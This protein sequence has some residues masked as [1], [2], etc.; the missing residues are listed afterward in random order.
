[1][2]R[3]TAPALRTR[4][5]VV[6]ATL[7][8]ALAMLAL[9]A[10]GTST[11]PQTQ[12]TT[13]PDAATI[14]QKAEAAS[15]KDVTYTIALTETV[16]GQTINATGTGGETTSPKRLQMTLTV[17]VPGKSYS[18]TVDEVIDYTAKTA[19][20]KTS[21]VPGQTAKWTK[22]SL[23]KF[24]GNSAVDVSAISDL[25]S[26]KNPKM[27]GSDTVDGVAVWHLQSTQSNNAATGTPATTGASATATANASAAA[28]TSTSD[29]YVRQ[30][31]GLPARMTINETGTSPV[32]ATIDFT[33]YNTGLTIAIPKV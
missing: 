4:L 28:A 29:L 10:C 7:L 30:D 1:M 27:I 9:A 33:K 20:T 31:N 18:A 3:S 13:L 17:P 24:L 16:S 22:T 8:A 2:T 21:G 14:L 25:T 19:Y 12:T 6:A 11:A 5:F 23:A 15:F 26:F 32:N